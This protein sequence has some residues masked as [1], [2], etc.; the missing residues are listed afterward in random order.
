MVVRGLS[1]SLN[2]AD[3]ILNILIQANTTHSTQAGQRA[4]HC[5]KVAELTYLLKYSMRTV[6]TSQRQD[7]EQSR[8]VAELTNLLKCSMRTVRTAHRQDREQSTE[9]R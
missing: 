6:R 5:R 9:D 3:R 7:R 2:M 4:E 1:G 8:Q